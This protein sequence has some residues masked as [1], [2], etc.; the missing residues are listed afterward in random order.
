MLDGAFTV[1]ASAVEM[2]IVLGSVGSEV[3]LEVSH[4]FDHTFIVLPVP[5]EFVDVE[6]WFLTLQSS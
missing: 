6:G 3:E 2:V 4:S 5:I 1:E